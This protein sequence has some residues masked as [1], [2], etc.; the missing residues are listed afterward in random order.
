MATSPSED[1][2]FL[3][4]W[5]PK[6]ISKPLPT[7][8]FFYG[9]SWSWGGTSFVLYDGERILQKHGNVIVV[10]VNYRLGALG[11]LAGRG[12]SGNFGLLDQRQ[13]MKWV[14]AVLSQVRFLFFIYFFKKK[15][16][17]KQTKGSRK[18]CRFR[19]RSN[20]AY[21]LGRKRWWWKCFQSLGSSKQLAI[22]STCNH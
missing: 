11:F 17:N 18:H 8:M 16:T 13:A 21:D 2:L 1:C 15:K 22:L 3:N 7:M 20:S 10:T 5:T 14:M 12:L 4:I 6:K 19:R 9:G